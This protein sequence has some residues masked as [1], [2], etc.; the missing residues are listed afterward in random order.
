MLA[1]ADLVMAGLHLD[2]KLLQGI[3]HVLANVD[4]LVSAQVEKRL[5]RR[6]STTCPVVKGE[7]EEL[8]FGAGVEDVAFGLPPLASIR[9]RIPRGSPLERFAIGA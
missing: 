9:F 5:D 1:D 2:A 7:Q 8:E 4:R 3:D 6:P